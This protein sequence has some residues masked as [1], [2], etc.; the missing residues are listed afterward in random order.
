MK[1][2]IV[3]QHIYEY[4]HST[5][6]YSQANELVNRFVIDSPKE[7]PIWSAGDMTSFDMMY[8]RAIGMSYRQILDYAKL[9]HQI[10]KTKLLIPGDYTTSLEYRLAVKNLELHAKSL[11]L[12]PSKFNSTTY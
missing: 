7:G 10:V 4:N 12:R 3:C 1:A 6:D 2:A 5:M 8:F 11:S 9:T